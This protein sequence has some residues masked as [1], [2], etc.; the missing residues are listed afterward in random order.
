MPA[1]RYD[2]FVVAAIQLMTAVDLYES[3]GDRFSVITLAGAADAILMQLALRRR[4]ISVADVICQEWTRQGKQTPSRSRVTS[5][6]NN[7]L[8]INAIKHMD[9]QEDDH[10]TMDAE[11]SARFALLNRLLKNPTIRAN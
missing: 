6:V 8:G 1:Q 3:D 2:K 4:G 9:S 11:I 7:A 10:V 5:I